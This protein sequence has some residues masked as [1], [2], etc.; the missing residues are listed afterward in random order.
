MSPLRRPSTIK[1]TK[2]SP[3][4]YLYSFTT[5]ELDTIITRSKHISELVKLGRTSLAFVKYPTAFLNESSGKSLV[6]LFLLL[7]VT[8]LRWD[9]VCHQPRCAGLVIVSF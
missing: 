7:L 6:A 4:S 8:L 1:M 2:L 9:L 3:S 5:N